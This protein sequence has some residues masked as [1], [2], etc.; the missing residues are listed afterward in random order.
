MS[1]PEDISEG[2]KILGL[3]SLDEL[4]ESVITIKDVELCGCTVLVYRN[5]IVENTALNIQRKTISVGETSKNVIVGVCDIS[6]RNEIGAKLLD[7]NYAFIDA[8]VLYSFDMISGETLVSI[9]CLRD[10]V[11]QRKDYTKNELA[12]CQDDELFNYI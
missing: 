3:S 2:M 7:E 10:R 8:V 11:P 12:F 4:N 5:K 6:M 9:F 1:L